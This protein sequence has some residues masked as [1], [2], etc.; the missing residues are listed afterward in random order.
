MFRRIARMR[1]RRSPLSTNRL[2]QRMQR[3]MKRRRVRLVP[4]PQM[5]DNGG[6]PPLAK[7]TQ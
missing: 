1:K 4:P 3:C 6:V 5:R 2:Q 7:G